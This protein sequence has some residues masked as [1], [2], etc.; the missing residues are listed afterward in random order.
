MLRSYQSDFL[1]Q[2]LNISIADSLIIYLFAI[3]TEIADS[4]A[5]YA[6]IKYKN[7]NAGLYGKIDDIVIPYAKDGKWHTSD[8][9][10]LEANDIHTFEPMSY[11]K[12]GS[13]ASIEFEGTQI[14]IGY[15]AFFDSYEAAAA[16]QARTLLTGEVPVE[17]AGHTCVGVKTEAK[18]ATCMEP[19]NIAYWTC[20]CGKIF[21]DEVFQQVTTLAYERKHLNQRLLCAVI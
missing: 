8:V 2:G 9:I 12:D 15:V 21:A 16:S 18:E 13:Y 20:G 4:A 6:V 3:G 1:F 14:E 11:I 5:K 7:E 19:G 10:V 17:V